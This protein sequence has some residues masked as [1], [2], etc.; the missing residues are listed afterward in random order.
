MQLLHQFQAGINVAFCLWATPTH[1]QFEL[2]DSR[3]IAKA[4]FA[5]SATL[6]DFC[7]RWSSAQVFRDIFDL[8]VEALPLTEFGH[9]TQRWSLSVTQ[10]NE[11]H[12]QLKKLEEL[13]VQ[14]KV[15]DMLSS[16]SQGARPSYSAPT[17]EETISIQF[18]VRQ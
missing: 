6:N 4:F 14:Q 3:S 11:L 15:I 17:I 2:Y 13:R 8:V 12:G 10:A 18:E 1:Q 16:M 7:V 5:C 9:F